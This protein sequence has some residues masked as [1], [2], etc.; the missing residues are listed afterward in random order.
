MKLIDKK[1][2]WNI[3]IPHW[4]L[5]YPGHLIDF[6]LKSPGLNYYK[7]TQKSNDSNQSK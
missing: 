7:K 6:L 2:C 3:L 1:K 5:K 4:V